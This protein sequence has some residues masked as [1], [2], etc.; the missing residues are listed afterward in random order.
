[1]PAV[2]QHQR[3]DHD[4]D[5]EAEDQG[6]ADP[7]GEGGE[8]TDEARNRAEGLPRSLRRGGA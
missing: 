6:A 5:G 7:I 2:L 8:P 1:M 3:I 4:G